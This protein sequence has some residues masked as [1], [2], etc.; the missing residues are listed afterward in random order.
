MSYKG[1]QSQ[2]ESDTFAKNVEDMKNVLLLCTV[3]WAQASFS[4]G[5][6]LSKPAL[7]FADVTLG[8]PSILAFD[9]SFSGYSCDSVEVFLEQNDNA[10]SSN[11]LGSGAKIAAV[12]QSISVDFNPESNIEYTGSITFV[13][14]CPGELS[15]TV[16]INLL[17][18][19]RL[20]NSKYASTFNLWDVA[21]R[22]ELKTISSAGYQSL[23]YSAARDEMYGDI[24]NVGGDVTC[25][26]T[27]RS[28]TFNTRTGANANSFNCEHTFPQGFFNQASPMR[29]DIHHLFPTDVNSNS[30]RGNLPFGVVSG[31][32]SWSE[33]GSKKNSSRFEPRDDHKGDVARA[34][35]YF[36]TRYQDYS[37]HFAGQVQVMRDWNAADPVST[38]EMDRNDAIENYQNNRNPF[39]DFP[40][41]EE[42]IYSFT[43]QQNRPRQASMFIP[44]DSAGTTMSLPGP[45]DT[46]VLTL[47]NNGEKA[48]SVGRIPSLDEGSGTIANWP[49]AMDSV[50]IEAGAS[51]DV[52]VVLSSESYKPMLI[53]NISGQDPFS[54]T[55]Y[56]NSTVGIEEQDELN[57]SVYPNPVKAGE[58]IR[59]EGMEP[60]QTV[61][62]YSLAGVKVLETQASS[63]VS[64][65]VPGVYLIRIEN[66]PNNRFHKLIVTE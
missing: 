25:V 66:E 44:L 62:V 7:N 26:Y 49:S 63:L 2:I 8:N 60:H 32:P 57:W 61:A 64:P 52:A 11:D 38:K 19:G 37:S 65:I 36:V 14:S 33:G 23:S 54:L 20:G 29:S 56:M 47:I 53:S 12:D 35:M 55:Y 45:I 5:I 16:S 30:Q 42:R 51:F 4:Q 48:I 40:G 28:A 58:V 3:L 59:F 1:G 18:N 43:S 17:G 34:M 10:Y 27:G 13:L 31:T 21:L 39:V 41:F 15:E 6:Q 22:S 50:A 46:L 24:D 9:I